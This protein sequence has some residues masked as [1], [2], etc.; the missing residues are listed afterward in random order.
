MMSTA[1]FL[2]FGEKN[3]KFD[4]KEG[5]KWLFL[6]GGGQWTDLETKR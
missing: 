2:I 6:G 1:F 5:V 3:P 4:L